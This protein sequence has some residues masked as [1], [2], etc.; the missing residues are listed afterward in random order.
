M[1][2]EDDGRWDLSEGGLSFNRN[3]TTD[4]FLLMLVALI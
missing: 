2:R 3:T 1:E 4:C